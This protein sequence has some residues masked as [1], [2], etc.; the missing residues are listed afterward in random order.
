MRAKAKKLTVNALVTAR[1]YPPT[2]AVLVEE[3][4]KNVIIAIALI[5]PLLSGCGAVMSWNQMQMTVAQKKATQTLMAACESGN[6]DAC[7]TVSGGALRGL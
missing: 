6:M 1:R 2:N 4:L 3:K 7:T 5:A